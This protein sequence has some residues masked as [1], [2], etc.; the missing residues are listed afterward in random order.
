MAA[1]LQFAS[2]AIAWDAPI[3]LNNRSVGFLELMYAAEAILNNPAATDA[4]LPAMELDLAR[5]H[6]AN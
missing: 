3:Q 4:E 2:G 1:W 6:P 5:V